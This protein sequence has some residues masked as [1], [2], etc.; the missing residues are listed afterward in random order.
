MK[1]DTPQK[2][3]G[4]F[5]RWFAYLMR[6]KALLFTAYISVII[7]LTIE[8]L[9]PK[10]VGFVIDNMVKA[11]TP[12]AALPFI[13][14]VTIRNGFLII[15]GC[16]IGL[17]LLRSLV[18][19][20]RTLTLTLI[21]EKIHLDI[22]KD[23]YDHIQRLPISYFD[24]TYTGR[25]MARITTDADA[26]W[27]LVHDGTLGVIAPA[28]T[29]VTILIILLKLHFTLALYSLGVMPFLVF[30]FIKTRGK[31][32]NF[33]RAQREALAQIFSRLQERIGGIRLIKL[34]GREETESASFT[35]DLQELYTRNIEM[36]K[37]FGRLNAANMF[38]TGTATALILCFGGIAASQGSLKPGELIQFYLYAGMLFGPL[39][40]ITGASARI[41]TQAEIAMERIFRLLDTPVADE[42]TGPSDPCPML[43]GTIEFKA[44]TFA[45]PNGKTVLEDVSF[46]IPAGQTVALVG[47]SGVGKT[48]LINLLS[49]FYHPQ[50]GTILCDGLDISQYDVASFRNQIS[51]V[52][53]DNILFA[54]SIAEN[55]KFANKEATLDEVKEAARRAN[56]YDFITALPEQYDTDI[57]EHG[58]T[59]SG[60]QKQRLNIARALLRK[61][62][63]FIL[64]EPTSALDAESETIILEA[65]ESVFADRTCLVIAHRLSTVIKADRI[66]VFNEGRI[67]QDGTHQELFNQE[68]LYQEL[69]RKQFVGYGGSEPDEEKK[70]QR[71]EKDH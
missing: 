67:V 56:A 14:S 70:N 47:P 58:V 35:A 16:L 36:M 42:L 31:A 40:G 37:A 53:Q 44:I 20:S 59:L 29:I 51:Y 34:F 50:S 6:H 54:G 3:R 62:A 52:T 39:I 38:I 55:L 49:R 21:G 64:D 57:G 69:C 68:G 24:N 41:F 48:T 63:I 19:Y 17:Y 71:L 66:L 18:T 26:L 15:L 33:G 13:G 23:L 25:I 61:P 22:R 27:H 43:E 65:L 28:I 30:F 2:K 5:R 1:S 12:N 45:Y 7:A 11:D 9:L 60:G 10:I 32:K 4:H 8:V 46:K